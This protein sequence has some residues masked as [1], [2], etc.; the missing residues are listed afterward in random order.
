MQPA[1]LAEIENNDL[2][3][4]TMSLLER[5]RPYLATIAAAIGITFVALAAWTLISS[6]QDS[7]RAG[8]WDACLAAISSGDAQQLNDVAARYPGTPAGA[9]SQILLADAALASGCQLAFTDKQQA[10]ERFR[11]AADLYAVAMSRPAGGLVTE[12]AMFGLAKA[13]EALGEFEPARKG[14]EALVDE[15]PN[16]P[17]RELAGERAAALARPAVTGWYDW[18]RSHDVSAPPTAESTAPA[19]GGGAA[20]QILSGTSG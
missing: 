18:F 11:A 2:A 20:E 15:Y 9:W 4:A 6:R 13:R 19:T 8:A 10:T 3:Q 14:Y 17:L 16:S 12:R 1:E 7:E 5:I